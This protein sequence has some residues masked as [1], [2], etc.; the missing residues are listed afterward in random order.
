MLNV[1]NC[2]TAEARGGAV[3][4]DGCEALL[5]GTLDVLRRSTQLLNSRGKVPLL[6]NPAS[7]ARPPGQKIW[8]DEV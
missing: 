1:P 7:F 3:R 4:W 8:L 6:A 2:S 5:N